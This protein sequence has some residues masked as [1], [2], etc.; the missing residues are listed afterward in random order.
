[1][2]VGS[3][4]LL[5]LV[6]SPV[7]TPYGFA[8][9]VRLS[10]IEPRHGAS[11]KAANEGH[12]ARGEEPKR[13]ALFRDFGQSNSNRKKIR[14]SAAASIDGT[15]RAARHRS[16]VNGTELKAKHNASINGTQ[17]GAGR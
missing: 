2:K 3:Y 1:M 5:A 16:S 10:T 14:G 7:A 11:G 9:G 15:E 13:R 17:M 4:L 6:L 8:A 12:S